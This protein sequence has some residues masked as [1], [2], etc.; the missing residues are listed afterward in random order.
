M[1]RQKKACHLADHL[2]QDIIAFHQL[3]YAEQERRLRKW[4]GGNDNDSFTVDLQEGGSF[5]VCKHGLTRMFGLPRGF[6]KRMFQDCGDI[7]T[8]QPRTNGTSIAS[9][10]PLV[11][12]PANSNPDNVIA[13]RRFESWFFHPVNLLQQGTFK[14]ALLPRRLITRMDPRRSK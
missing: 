6:L 2:E 7:D 14:G 10:S 4:K 8:T 13:M 12:G 1:Y 9:G 3:D 11:K 5:G